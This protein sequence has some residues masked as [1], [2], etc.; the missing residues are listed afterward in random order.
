MNNYY[1]Q[2]FKEKVFCSYLSAWYS[3]SH[4]TSLTFFHKKLYKINALNW[5]FSEF[6]HKHSR[7]LGASNFYL[8][9]CLLDISSLGIITWG[10][11][12]INLIQNGKLLW[13]NYSVQSTIIKYKSGQCEVSSRACSCKIKKQMR[14]WT[15]LCGDQDWGRG[16]GATG[17]CAEWRT[18]EPVVR[19]GSKQARTARPGSGGLRKLVILKGHI[20]KDLFTSL[21]SANP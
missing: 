20:D 6:F 7:D 3:A 8:F 12:L 16:M 18:S 13:I 5:M 10:C 2:I 14:S 19:A 21:N 1:S 9:L 11:N 15:D 17:E 4:V